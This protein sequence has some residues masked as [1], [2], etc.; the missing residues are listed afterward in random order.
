MRKSGVT[1]IEGIGSESESSMLESSKESNVGDGWGSFLLVYLDVELTL[2]VIIHSDD[3]EWRH[4][5]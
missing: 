2:I 3:E 5:D 1:Q 4:A